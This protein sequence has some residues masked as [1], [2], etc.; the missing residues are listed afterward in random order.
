M[1]GVSTAAPEVDTVS[2]YYMVSV[3]G[4]YTGKNYSKVDTAKD[5]A[6]NMSFDCECEVVVHQ[7]NIVVN[8]KYDYDVPRGEVTLLW[9]APTE[10]VND[11]VPLLLSEIK[12][13]TITYWQEGGRKET[14]DVQKDLNEITVH[15]LERGKWFF[16][17]RTVDTDGLESEWFKT[18]EKMI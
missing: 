4:A 7:P 14:F 18:L 15:G 13:Y 12:H 10:R 9:D 3:K 16:K 8:T 17:I 6:I 1:C 11:N 2:G 5:A